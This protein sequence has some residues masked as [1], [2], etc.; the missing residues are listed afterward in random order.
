MLK[1]HVNIGTMGHIDCV[2]RGKA[3]LLHDTWLVALPL[4]PVQAALD[5]II[6][7]FN[8][9][10]SNFGAVAGITACVV[11]CS[12]ADQFRKSLEEVL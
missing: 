4:F 1:S 10:C 8:A 5:G 6:F 2:R 7:A 11:G 12:Q 9:K 3:Q